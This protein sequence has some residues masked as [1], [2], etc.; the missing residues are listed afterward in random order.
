[1]R[2]LTPILIPSSH[3]DLNVLLLLS[4]RKSCPSLDKI[5]IENGLLSNSTEMPVV[6]TLD[7][8]QH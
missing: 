3:K 4:L 7:P 1:M 2:L 5:L 6:L 8:L